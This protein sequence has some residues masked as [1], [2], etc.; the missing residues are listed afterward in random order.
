MYLRLLIPITF[1]K[2]LLYVRECFVCMVGLCTTPYRAQAGKNR[3]SETLE[4][5]FQQ[6]LLPMCLLGMEPKSSG[7]ATSAVNH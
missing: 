1:L 3:V 2:D 4:L 6:L 5:E 7:R